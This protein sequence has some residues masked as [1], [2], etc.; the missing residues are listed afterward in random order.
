ML[1]SVGAVQISIRIMQIRRV[2]GRL[3]TPTKRAG[4]VF[5]STVFVSSFCGAGIA[6]CSTAEPACASAAAHNVAVEQTT[7]DAP[8]APKAFVPSHCGADLK[9]RLI[10]VFD[11]ESVP[12]EIFRHISAEYDELG[13]IE[14]G[15]VGETVKPHVF[16]QIGIVDTE[17]VRKLC[18]LI[19]SDGVFTS[20]AEPIIFCDIG[21]GVGNVLMQVLAEVRQCA[22]VVGVEVIPSR[23][24]MAI[25]AF[26]NAKSSFPK[27]FRTSTTEVTT[28]T[29]VTAST[30]VEGTGPVS[31][32]ILES[33]SVVHKEKLITTKD[34]SF[35]MVDLVA[36][37][38][39]LANDGV[40]VIFSHSWMFDDDLMAKFAEMVCQ[41]GPQLR[42]VFTSRPFSTP[43][44]EPLLPSGWTCAGVTTLSADWNSKSPFYVYIRNDAVGLG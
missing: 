41:S 2:L 7:V 42:M 34:A 23:H 44:G 24:R 13:Q 4:M 28:T 25:T 22:K 40:N 6:F 9:G 3:A 27:W 15:E 14:V 43:R 5:S 32:S 11:D 20:N 29:T 31:S 12:K 35:H 37:G 36:A 21:S 8:N 30:T 39:L 17:G 33:S 18:R 1:A 10:P 19:L 16:S 38:P 26:E